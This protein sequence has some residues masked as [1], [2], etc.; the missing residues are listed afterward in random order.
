MIEANNPNLKTWLEVTESSDF[1]IQN[2]PFGIAFI[3]YS[4]FGVSRI[5]DTAINLSKL[6]ELGAFDGILYENCFDK[7]YLN[8]FLKK[9]KSVWRSVRNRISEI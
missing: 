8:D 1:P 7:E 9:K 4:K 6:Y 3:D 5:G 2:I